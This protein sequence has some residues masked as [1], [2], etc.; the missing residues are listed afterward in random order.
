[1]SAAAVFYDE[2]PSATPSKRILGVKY[3]VKA[4]GIIGMPG[5][6]QG[7]ST[8]NTEDGA[9]GTAPGR[10]SRRGDHRRRDRNQLPR[11][12]RHEPLP[13][14]NTKIMTSP[15][16]CFED[17]FVGQ[18]VSN[19]CNQGVNTQ[20]VNCYYDTGNWPTENTVAGLQFIRGYSN[21][22]VRSRPAPQL[23][24]AYLD[25][26]SPA[27]CGCLLRAAPAG[28]VH[29]ASACDEHGGRVVGPYDPGRARTAARHA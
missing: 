8:Y 22:N 24:K 1:M 3:F 19:L 11:S 5:G 6:L 14:P 17:N 23:R 13:D 9:G 12:V 18:S 25:S 7:W 10:T 16:P 4:P 29:R 26:P 20:I 2:D 27:T 28:Y 15:A 21:G